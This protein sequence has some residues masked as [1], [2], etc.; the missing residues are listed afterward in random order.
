MKNQAI[1]NENQVILFKKIHQSLPDKNS[2]VYVLS[3]LLGVGIDATYRRIRGEKPINYEEAIKLCRYFQISMDS[4]ADIDPDKNRIQ[5]NYTPLN[6]RNLT[7]YMLYIQVLSTNVE[8]TRSIPESE[9][10]MS[11]SDVSVFSLLP[12]NESTFF[13][14]YSWCKNVYGF[15][16]GYDEFVKELDTTELLKCYEKIVRNYQLIPSTEI[17]TS[18]TIDTFLRLLNYHYETGSFND[19]KIPLLLCE[20][21]LDLINTLQ[22][23]TEKGTK[24]AK[25][26]PFKFYVSE[27]DLENTF[28][29]FKQQE[30]TA[31]VIK[32]FT[33]NSLTT[34]DERLCREVE[35][36]LN[37]SAQRATL[38]SGAS[39]KERY[40]FFTGQ[41]KKIQFLIEKI[42]L[43]SEE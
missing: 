36:W 35:N 8:R 15:S 22:C 14:L 39:A 1:K 17:W 29:L 37:N 4:L 6:L 11:A 31:C 34:F 28:I 16:G 25:D 18:N 38:I 27:T 32:L 2:L 26:V 30:K 43:D 20:Q 9:I 41:R 24:G 40:R 33:I 42:H 23:W 3:D 19:E 5:C 13:K 12:Y 10:L 7:D 21:L